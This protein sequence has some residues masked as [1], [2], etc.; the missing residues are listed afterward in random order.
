M[1][2]DYGNPSSITFFGP[3]CINVD[4]PMS[5]MTYI[6]KEV[7]YNGV[8]A[9]PFGALI[10]KKRI[11][12]L[13]PIMGVALGLEITTTIVSTVVSYVDP[14]SD[15]NRLKEAEKRDIIRDKQI[16]DFMQQMR[17]SVDQFKQPR[18][19]A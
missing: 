16:Q 1:R 2:S 9:V 5:K 4:E 6:K 8:I 12:L 19:T 7:S 3:P 10:R 18:S 17:L 14:D 11:P 15:Q 13:L